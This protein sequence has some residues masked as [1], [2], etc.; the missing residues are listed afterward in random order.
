M[1]RSVWDLNVSG[2]EN[3]I[4]PGHTSF[5]SLKNVLKCLCLFGFQ[6]LR[7]Q[8]DDVQSMSRYWFSFH[9]STD[10]PD[11]HAFFHAGAGGRL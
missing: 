3:V 8:H 6:P 11:A 4:Y 7:K 9:A 2:K 1:V 5:Q 10:H